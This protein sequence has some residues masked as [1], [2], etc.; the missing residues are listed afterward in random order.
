MIHVD[1]VYQTVQALAN[2]EQRGYITPQEYNLF[3][4]QAQQD[5]FEQYFYD[6]NAM[7]SQRPQQSLIGDSTSMLHQ[8][9]KTFYNPSVPMIAGNLPIGDGLVYGKIWWQY[10][11]MS[12][13]EILEATPEFVRDISQSTW[14]SNAADP[15]FVRQGQHSIQVWANSPS[16]YSPIAPAQYALNVSH[17]LIARRPTLVYWGYVVVNEKP[18]YDPVTSAHFDLDISEQT[19]LIIKILSLAG[20]SIEDPQLVSAATSIEQNN[21][22]EESK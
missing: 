16:P 19:D 9:L 12:Q 20:I 5:I 15:M 13:L 18:T 7:R 6:L 22:T 17:E 14:H 4:N 1:T 8:K 11:T 10:G 3:A 21:K 2:K